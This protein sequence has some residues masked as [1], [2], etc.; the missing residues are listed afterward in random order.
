MDEIEMDFVLWHEHWVPLKP[1]HELAEGVVR[2]SVEDLR[3]FEGARIALIVSQAQSKELTFDQLCKIQVDYFNAMAYMIL[4][5]G[6]DNRFA[7][8]FSPDGYLYYQDPRAI[9]GFNTRPP[10]VE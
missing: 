10:K 2:A 9:S 4:E 3:Y 1:A 5:Y 6:I 8:R 7:W